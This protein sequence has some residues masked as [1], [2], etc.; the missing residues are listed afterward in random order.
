MVA[1]MEGHM[2]TAMWTSTYQGNLAVATGE[3]PIW[4]QL[5]P[6]QSVQYG[7]ISQGDQ[8]ATWW[9]DDYLGPLHHGR[10]KVAGIDSYP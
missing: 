10:G 7:S 1:G 5:K 9:Q 3:C 2:G 8:L 4:Q 6:T